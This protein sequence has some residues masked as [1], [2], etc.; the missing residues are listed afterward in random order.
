[1]K[2]TRS[3]NL[4]ARVAFAFGAALLLESRVLSQ[5]PD[6]LYPEMDV[7]FVEEKEDKREKTYVQK[8]ALR[9]ELS[10]RYSEHVIEEYLPK[11]EAIVKRS[12][13]ELSSW[14]DWRTL[15]GQLAVSWEESRKHEKTGTRPS[16]QDQWEKQHASFLA[17]IKQG[18]A[19]L[20]LWRAGVATETS[21][22]QKEADEAPGRFDAI[23]KNMAITD[24]IWSKAIELAAAG[25]GATWS[26]EELKTAQDAYA[27]LKG[28][29]DLVA[30]TY[31]AI[32]SAYDYAVKEKAEKPRK[33]MTTDETATL[34]N[35][36]AAVS[37]YPLV[38]KI[39]TQPVQEWA[40]L[41]DAAYDAD[42]KAWEAM[43][44]AFE[45]VKSGS[46]RASS[47]YKDC[48]WSSTPAE[49]IQGSLEKLATAIA[50]AGKRIEGAEAKIFEDKAL[51][52]KEYRRILELIRLG[53]PE[54]ERPLQLE[55]AR[56]KTDDEAA[57]AE[58]KVKE[59]RAAAKKYDEEIA[60][61]KSDHRAR[62]K[63][64]GIPPEDWAD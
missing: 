32:L 37:T 44:K 56:A 3:S 6:S 21:I 33:N 45:P 34:G 18:G 13:P 64:L 35:W 52:E 5:V 14:T 29:R 4:S 48:P 1:M 49:C 23:R 51:S 25:S 30:S 46:I 62:R 15:G 31:S 8:T 11:F 9:W 20:M 55:A 16:D 57:R 7:P 41:V 26:R 42:V 17:G 63:G 22:L 19:S 38:Q 61:I 60:K 12:Q 39:Y 10:R 40:K 24:P 47:P 59:F 36:K 28:K 50:G 53:S 54:A 2:H 27:E 58:K 43:Q